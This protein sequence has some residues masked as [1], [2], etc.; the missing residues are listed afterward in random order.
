LIT[1]YKVN[2]FK[3]IINSE[4]VIQKGLHPSNIPKQLKM[5]TI[6]NPKNKVTGLPVSTIIKAG[7]LVGALDICFA[8]L[9]SYIKRGATPQTV[10]QYISR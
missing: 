9:Y 6:I 8:F 4:Y 5:T 2:T 10:L 7:L 3:I 1:P